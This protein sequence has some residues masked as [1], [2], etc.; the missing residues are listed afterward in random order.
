M[1]ATILSP[2][3]TCLRCR[4]ALSSCWC[5]ASTTERTRA[6]LILLQH[7]R[8]ARNPIGTAR[9]AHLSVADSQIRVGIRFGDDPAILAMLA[10]PNRRN[11]V[12]YPSPTAHP[13][14]E[15]PN[16]EL[17]LRIFLLDGT[18]WQAKKL[19]QAN[20]WLRA[21]PA[22]RL[23]PQTAGQYRIRRE[24]AAHCLATIEAVVQL[25]DVLEG[26]KG[27]HAPL[28]QPF[29]VM[30]E[31]QMAHAQSAARA[32]R[33]R[34]RPR[35]Q[36]VCPPLIEL[37][38]VL[39]RLLL[40]HAEGNGWP[41]KRPRT[42]SDGGGL[43]LLQWLA[44][45]PSTGETFHALM[46]T[47]SLAPKALQLQGLS[48]S[49][50]REAVSQAELLSRW[51]QFARP[52]DIWCSWGYFPTALL[53][54]VGGAVPPFINLQSVCHAWLQRRVPQVEQAITALG[55]PAV[56]AEL[57][58]RGG[59]RLAEMAATVRALADIRPDPAP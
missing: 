18:W 24:P 20:P 11:V 29:H 7:P 41:A 50:L 52:D 47:Q 53:K 59:R 3:A 51:Q 10:D 5:A 16:S 2:R 9:M 22:Y 31:R 4:L 40:V 48:E 54:Q 46:Q 25:L 23:T 36:R 55:I 57:P 14:E 6:E 43:E 26:Q 8:E 39:P 30:V 38:S 45:R 58:G 19:W 37:Q 42:P 1:S 33:M 32:P 13:A 49:Q 56:Q 28:L 15:L 34:A 44:L 21:L 35:P 12:L 17:P 27:Q